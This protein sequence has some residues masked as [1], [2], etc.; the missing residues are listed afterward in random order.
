MS[1]AWFFESL[2]QNNSIFNTPTHSSVLFF[3]NFHSRKKLIRVIITL[4]YVLVQHGGWVIFS[5]NS[6]TNIHQKRDYF[7]FELWWSSASLMVCVLLR[8]ENRESSWYPLPGSS[9]FGLAVRLCSWVTTLKINFS[10]FTFQEQF[11]WPEVFSIRCG[12]NGACQ[13]H[14]PPPLIRLPPPVARPPSATR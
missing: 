1:Y 14:R 7:R 6:S 11:V 9:L 12:G 8:F 13:Y 3:V 4:K 5:T 10:R 2:S